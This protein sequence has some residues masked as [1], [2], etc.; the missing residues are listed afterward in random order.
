MSLDLARLTD[1][2]HPELLRQ[3]TN[4]TCYQFV[5]A[6]IQKLRASGASAHLVCKTRGEGQYTPP[7]FTPFEIV[8]LDAK[9][10]WCTGVSHD[11]IWYNG[12][13]FDTIGRGNDSPEPIFNADGSRM[14]G[15]PAWNPIP[16]EYWRPNNPPYLL[17]SI[18]EAPPTP[19]P[20]QTPAY[21]PYPPNESDVDG[22]GVAL[23]ADF[24]MAG[25]P[26]NPQMFRFAFRVAY[27]WLTKEVPDLPASVAK[28]RK[29]WRA[30]LGVPPL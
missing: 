11:A 2:E 9:R 29:E 28:H 7:G 10:Y 17:D 23:F 25:Q 15:E 26:P 27:S 5:V 12:L 8:G 21:P 22:A 3:N 14:T 19:P 24:G 13:Q 20:S 6:L 1:R 18:P 16:K 30:I 4:A